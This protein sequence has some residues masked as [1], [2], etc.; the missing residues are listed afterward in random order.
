MRRKQKK[1]VQG[2][3]SKTYVYMEGRKKCYHNGDK[4]SGDLKYSQPQITFLLVEPF[5]FHKRLGEMSYLVRYPG[6]GP[7]NDIYC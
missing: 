6:T 5:E 3:S 1:F 2:K 7:S 4:K